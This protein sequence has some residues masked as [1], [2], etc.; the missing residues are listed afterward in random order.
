MDLREELENHFGEEKYVS[1]GVHVKA[2]M[3]SSSPID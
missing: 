1:E 2:Q 3:E